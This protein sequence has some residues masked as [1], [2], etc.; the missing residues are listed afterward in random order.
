MQRVFG[1]RDQVF[2]GFSAAA[3]DP[4]WSCATVLLMIVGT[5]CA[6]MAVLAFRTMWK[7]DGRKGRFDNP[8]RHRTTTAVIGGSSKEPRIVARSR[9]DR[10]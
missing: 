5:M 4:T 2:D 6:I 3:R 10:D 1:W 8:F 9:W 7:S